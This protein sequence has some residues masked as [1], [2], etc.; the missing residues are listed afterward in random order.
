MIVSKSGVCKRCK[1]K[2]MLYS[3]GYCSYCYWI[4]LRE[5]NK[6]KKNIKPT[7]SYT[8]K[9]TGEKLV[10]NIVWK[11]QKGRCF[12]TGKFISHKDVMA[13]NFVHILSKAQNKYPAFKL[14]DKNIVMTVSRFHQLYDHGTK[15]K[16]YS[17]FADYKKN[18]DKF[19]ELK[20]ELVNEYQNVTS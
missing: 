11:K 3:M 10:F 5:K 17:E 15:D 14:Y 20:K 7:S 9:P 19:F 12:I 1:K 4:Q 6:N 8:K 16:M 2:K 18:I 13:S